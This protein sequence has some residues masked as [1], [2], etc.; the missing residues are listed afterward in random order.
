M[1]IITEHNIINDQIVYTLRGPYKIS[2][3]QMECA[4]RFQ[5]S[6]YN[7]VLPVHSLP[8]HLLLIFLLQ[9]F[10][11]DIMSYGLASF[12]LFCLCLS[13]PPT[14]K[15][16]KVVQPKVVPLKEVLPKVVP[17]KEAVMIYSYLIIYHKPLLAPDFMQFGPDFSR[18]VTHSK[19]SN[20]T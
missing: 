3:N 12:L 14:F 8:S 7:Q 17:L 4:F 16:A 15:P 9:M 10:L 20:V 19:W 2:S 1:S 11:H 13:S 5:C 6:S 18:A